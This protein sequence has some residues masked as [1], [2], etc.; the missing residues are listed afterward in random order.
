MFTNIISDTQPPVS[1]RKYT[2]AWIHLFQEAKRLYLLLLNLNDVIK[3]GR[4]TFTEI[5][6]PSML[7][8]TDARI[9]GR[10]SFR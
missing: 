8:E 10:Y 9:P 4:V 3:L 7:S 1:T 6:Y 5:V 2:Y